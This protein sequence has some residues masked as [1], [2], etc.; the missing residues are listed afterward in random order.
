MW[1]GDWIGGHFQGVSCQTEHQL[2]PSGPSAGSDIFIIIQFYTL[3]AYVYD[4]HNT[5]ATSMYAIVLV[6]VHMD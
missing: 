5:F 4:F 6:D 1:M 3:T 2:L